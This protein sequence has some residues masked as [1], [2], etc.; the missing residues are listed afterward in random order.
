ME[1]LASPALAITSTWLLLAWVATRVKLASATPL[2]VVWSAAPARHNSASNSA[3]P[4]K[5]IARQV[6]GVP[7]GIAPPLA[8]VTSAWTVKRPEVRRCS[9][10]ATTQ[11][12]PGSD[13]TAEAVW[14]VSI[15]VLATAGLWWVGT[16]ALA[17]IVM[18]PS[19]S[20]RKTSQARPLLSV[21]V[22]RDSPGALTTV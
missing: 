18:V 14:P 5:P 13:S 3:A 20:T 12:R 10:G 19:E 17:S 21:R 8:S 7:S 9:T 2:V 1:A 15:S 4:L 22:V 6:T 16:A 11:T